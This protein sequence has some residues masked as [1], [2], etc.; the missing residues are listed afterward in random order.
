MVAAA[1]NR[2]LFIN[3]QCRCCKNV[4]PLDVNLID[5]VFWKNGMPIQNAMPYL[6]AGE[7][8]LLISGTCEPCF[9]RMFSSEEPEDE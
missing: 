5:F 2:D 4:L 6:S 7:R 3:V 1:H 8:E 9:D